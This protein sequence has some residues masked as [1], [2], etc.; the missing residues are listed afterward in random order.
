LSAPHK[1]D[2]KLI[3]PLDFEP[4]RGAFVCES[5]EITKWFWKDAYRDHSNRLCRVFC[6]GEDRARPSGIFAIGVEVFAFKDLIHRSN[7]LK[8][9]PDYKIPAVE[10][11]YVAVASHQVGLGI[12]SGL[13]VEGLRIAKF[14][15]ESVGIKIVTLVPENESNRK[16]YSEAG[17]KLL[18]KCPKR[19][20]LMYMTDQDLLGS[21][22]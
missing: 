1:F 3:R 13:F 19:P 20:G 4:E 10:L 21:G 9:N 6:Y 16:F 22:L 17:F 15:C 12:G 18:D 2:P 14:V 8:F 11:H 7:P 5:D